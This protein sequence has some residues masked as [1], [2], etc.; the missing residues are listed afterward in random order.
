MKKKGVTSE[1]LF[2]K[3]DQNRNNAMSAEELAAALKAEVGTEL[4]KDEIETLQ[5]FFRNKFGRTEI[6]PA[7]FKVMMNTKFDR[8]FQAQK[9]KRSLVAVEKALRKS[10]RNAE[11]IFAA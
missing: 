1:S 5:E 2:Q 3:Y 11:A 8:L 6:K 9:A 4:A 10:G 7:Q